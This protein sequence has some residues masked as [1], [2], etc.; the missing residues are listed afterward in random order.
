M[1]QELLRVVLGPAEQAAAI[2]QALQPLDVQTLETG[3]FCVLPLLGE[4]LALV[5][6]ADERVPLL[7]GTYRSSWYRN[8]L[9]LERLGATLPALREHGV[10]PLVVGGVSL[11]T[12]WYPRPGDRPI[13]LLELLIE[14]EHAEPVRTAAR[15]AGWRPAGR[16][17][18]RRRYVDDGGRTLV[19]HE[20]V[21]PFAAG[22][23]G[24]AGA[25][26]ALWSSSS[27]RPLLDEPARTL[28][29]P[30]ELLFTCALG[31][32][33]ITPPS[34]QWLLDAARMLTA[35]DGPE[36][37]ATVERA[38]VL[39]LVEPLRDAVRYLDRFIEG[40]VLEPWA[41]ALARE[42][43]RRRDAAAYR[44]GG[45]PLGRL[46]GLPLTLAAHL[47]ATSEQPVWRAAAGLPGHLAQ[48]WEAD[49][50]AAVPKVALR[51]LRRRA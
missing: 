29:A 39:H 42:T 48:A 20:G 51:K 6:P 49:S 7:Q 1:Q 28:G 14:P 12:R 43:S 27:V 19:V 11:A 33:T 2:W 30:D 25:L 38:R 47:R 26:T 3:S 21:P 40:D 16:R 45:A 24:P 22:P 9:A 35:D 4:R 18:G 41:R 32:R 36:V 46:G 37:Q 15:S 31:A 5:A 10:E 8:Q 44:L 13:V 50:V 34:M 17:A 23:L